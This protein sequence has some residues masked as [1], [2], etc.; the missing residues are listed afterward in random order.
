MGWIL[1]VPLLLH[2]VITDMIRVRWKGSTNLDHFDE[3]F[4]PS[5]DSSEN[6]HWKN[7]TEGQVSNDHI[8]TTFRPKRTRRWRRTHLCFA[9]HYGAEVIRERGP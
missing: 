1:L 3:I 6:S 7:G 9:T 5:S 4:S 8:A 2:E